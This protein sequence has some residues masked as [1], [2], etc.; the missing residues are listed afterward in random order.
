LPRGVDRLRCPDRLRSGLRAGR[1][2]P[3]VLSTSVLAGT[4]AR[5]VPCA[6]PGQF[7]ACPTSLLTARPSRR[8]HANCRLTIHHKVRRSVL[9]E[10][11]VFVRQTAPSGLEKGAAH[12]SVPFTGTGAASIGSRETRSRDVIRGAGGSLRSRRPW[13]G[14]ADR[15]RGTG[16][17]GVLD[18]PPRCAPP[19]FSRPQP[20]RPALHPAPAARS[21]G[22]LPV[23]LWPGWTAVRR[24]LNF[25][26]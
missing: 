24:A 23:K 6:L 15:S 2:S 10:P 16:G 3:A 26:R 20:K 7:L 13:A 8:R 25:T 17:T 22:F 11:I 9:R 14:A 4:E 5:A 12:E 19:R 21:S 18:L 1:A